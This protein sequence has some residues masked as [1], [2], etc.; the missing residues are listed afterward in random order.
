MAHLPP[1]QSSAQRALANRIQSLRV[2]QSLPASNAEQVD[3]AQVPSAPYTP[4]PLRSAA[5]AAVLA[6]L[7]A[8]GLAY[9][10]EFLDRRLRRVDEAEEIYGQPALATIPRA[11]SAA[12]GGMNGS[13]IDPAVREDIRYLRLNLTL[14]V[15]DKRSQKSW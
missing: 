12:L 15:P 7:F 1:G 3:A 14:A 6:L 8:G 4:K 9:G 2:A 11:S 13:A 10:L 5:F